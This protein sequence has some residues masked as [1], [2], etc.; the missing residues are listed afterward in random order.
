MPHSLKLDI[1]DQV[2]FRC[3]EILGWLRSLRYGRKSG[4]YTLELHVFDGELAKLDTYE[5]KRT[6]LP[7]AI[8]GRK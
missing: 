8:R 1:D 2:S 3:E 7:A 4:K 6:E 5:F